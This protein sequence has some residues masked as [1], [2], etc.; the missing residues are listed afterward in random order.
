MPLAAMAFA[1]AH[2]H[3]YA[4][5]WV[6]I[7]IPLLSII[8]Q[9]AKEYRRIL[10]DDVVLEHHSAVPPPADAH[11][12]EKSAAELATENWDAAIIVT[13]S[14]QFLESLFADSPAKCRK[15]HRLAKS[16]V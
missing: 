7:V 2:A 14:V 9:N 11:E 5:R 12:E 16:V 8:E 3:P 1:L 15:L 4:L 13:T 10:G 6:I